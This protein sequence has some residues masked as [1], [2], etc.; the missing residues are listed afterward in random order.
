MNAL[1]IS[2]GGGTGVGYLILEVKSVT[3]LLSSQHKLTSMLY[4]LHTIPKKRYT[5]E[6]IK[7]GKC[8]NYYCV[9]STQNNSSLVFYFCSVFNKHSFSTTYFFSIPDAPCLAIQ[10]SQ[11]RSAKEE[12]ARNSF[13]LPKY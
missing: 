5:T 7:A 13:V 12:K 10:K 1:F 8:I 9:Y 2:W 3:F 4:F 6:L 11:T